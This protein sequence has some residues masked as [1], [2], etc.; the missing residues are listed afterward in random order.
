MNRLSLY[1]LILLLL[2]ATV[3][4]GIEVY[5]NK[6]GREEESSSSEQGRGERTRPSPKAASHKPPVPHLVRQLA[7]PSKHLSE[8]IEAVRG[9]PDDLTPEEYTALLDII[10]QAS[11]PNLDSGRWYTLQN[12]IMEVLRQPRFEWDGYTGAMAGLVSD[13]NADPVMRD[14]A[15]QHLALHL[16]ERGDELPRERIDQGMNAFLGVLKGGREAHEQ[17]AGTTLMALCDLNTRRPDLIEPH[18]AALGETIVALVSGERS[19]SMSNQVAAIQAAG[20]MNFPETLPDIRR[21]ASGGAPNPSVELSS[22]A[23]LGY[24]ADPVDKSFLVELAQGSGRLRFAA[25]TALR[26]FQ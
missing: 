20:R 6:D 25:Q 12:E 3:F 26:N 5:G 11:P 23:A 18:R 16:G 9:L 7:D 2:G 24:F 17:V 1:A 14:Y 10:H 8:Q 21:F 4:L 19:A 13:R 15:A 22:I